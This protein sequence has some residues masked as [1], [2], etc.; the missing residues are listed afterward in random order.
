MGMDN[1]VPNQQTG[2]VLKGFLEVVWFELEIHVSR[3]V[4]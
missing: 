4:I 3:E 1:T 2:E